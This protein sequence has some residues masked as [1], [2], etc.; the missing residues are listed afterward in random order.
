MPYRIVLA[1]DHHL[2]R[3]GVKRIIEGI[4]DVQ[5]TGEVGDGLALMEFLKESVPD[6]I[7]LDITMPHLQGIEATRKIKELYPEVK[8][9]ILTM[10]KSKEH[11]HSAI[12]AGADGFLLKENAYADLISAIEVIQQGNTY[13][14]NLVYGHMVDFFRKQQRDWVQRPKVLSSRE[15]KVLALIAEGNSSKEIAEKLQIA[16]S[17]VQGHRVNLKKKLN[18]KKNADLIKYAIQNGYTSAEVSCP[19]D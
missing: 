18:I 8:I 19:A 3:E 6:L 13:I 17:T 11:L 5:V 1:D 14:S 12:L 16:V 7:V 15:K 10:H 2:F 4:A 9:L